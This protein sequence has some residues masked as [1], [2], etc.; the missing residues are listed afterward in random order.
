[1]KNQI[2]FYA[3]ENELVNVKIDF[4]LKLFDVKVF[5]EMRMLLHKRCSRT[6]STFPHHA[7]CIDLKY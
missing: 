7:K 2:C 1:M 4:L 3:T 6:F 5:F